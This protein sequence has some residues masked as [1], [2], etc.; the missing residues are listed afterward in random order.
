M[1]SWYTVKGRDYRVVMLENEADACSQRA[2]CARL[3][4]PESVTELKKD[5]KKGIS[6]NHLLG[7]YTWMTHRL[8][9]PR[10]KF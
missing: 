5:C 8:Q 9:K 3:D 4:T 1:V 6:M 7:K 2:L 10:E